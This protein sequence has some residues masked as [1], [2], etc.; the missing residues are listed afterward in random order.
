[1]FRKPSLV[2]L[3]RVEDLDRFAYAFSSSEALERGRKIPS[4]PKELTDG[5]LAMRVA[6]ETV[7]SSS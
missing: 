1:M 5:D 4:D 3:P 6:I 7:P 2:R